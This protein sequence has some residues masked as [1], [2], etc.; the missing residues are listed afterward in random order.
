M[1]LITI[2]NNAMYHLLGIRLTKSAPSS[3]REMRESIVY[4]K[5]YFGN[6]EIVVVEIGVLR[7]DNALNI[8]ENLNV[9][10]LYLIDPYEDY[11]DYM[12][13]TAYR[14]LNFSK[15]EKQA[16]AK[17]GKFQDKIVWIKKR[18]SDA[19]GDIP[20][21][22]DFI[23]IDGNHAY[24]YVREDIHNYYPKVSRG[25]ILAG[26]DIANLSVR[27]VAKAFCEF[28]VEYN[29]EPYISKTDWW[30]IKFPPRSNFRKNSKALTKRWKINYNSS[31]MS[32][33]KR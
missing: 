5:D 18:S 10:K 8:L 32:R 22:I 31:G 6:K 16:R 23:Y 14:G 17:L 27:G 26:H 24:E 1:K 30:V 12:K 21:D 4:A 13:I 3:F 20:N 25:G 7:G 11:P 29:L 9:K 2:I 15:V 33:A 28:V 19:V